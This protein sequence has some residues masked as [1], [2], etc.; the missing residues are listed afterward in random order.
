MQK[1]VI[2][3]KKQKAKNMEEKQEIVCC[4]NCDERLDVFVA[5]SFAGISRIKAKDLI[6]SGNVLVNGKKSKSCNKVLKNDVVSVVIPEEKPKEKYLIPIEFVYE[7]DD[8]IIL[9]KPK[10]MVVHSGAKNFCGTLVGELKKRDKMLPNKTV[11]VI[12]RL[13][14]DTCG[15]MIFAKTEHALKQLSFDMLKGK[16]IRKYVGI[17]C[18]NTKG[19]GGTIDKKI[20]VSKQNRTKMAIDKNGQTAI[21]HYKLLNR[22]NGFELLEFLLETGRTHQ[23]RVHCKSV[24][25]PLLGDEKYGDAKNEFGVKGQLLMSSYIEFLHPVSKQKMQFSLPLNLEFESVIRKIKNFSAKKD[26]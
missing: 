10:G 21:T 1:Y 22:F 2:V 12:H 3:N 14:K 25:H 15:L 19:V 24:G 8:I 5:K 17:V 13:D 26:I 7:D 18:G 11:G 20:A 23:I 6:K 4:E 16:I 9:N